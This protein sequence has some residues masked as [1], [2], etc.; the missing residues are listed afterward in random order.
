M[1]G[2]KVMIAKPCPSNPEKQNY[3]ERDRYGWLVLV[4]CGKKDK[5][6]ENRY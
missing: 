2:G 3:Y 5:K 1:L 6:E 4:K